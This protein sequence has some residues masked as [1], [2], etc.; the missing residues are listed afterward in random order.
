MCRA[1][2]PPWAI[3]A[4]WTGAIH[5]FF[6]RAYKA[7]ALLRVIC[8]LNRGA[9][10]KLAIKTVGESAAAGRFVFTSYGSL[11][12]E[13]RDAAASQGLKPEELNAVHWS[14]K[15]YWLCAPV[16]A[17]QKYWLAKRTAERL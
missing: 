15:S 11:P 9:V 7:V 17:K 5:G 14:G 2:L 4:L 10:N 3:G 13:V 12:I 1:W 8:F 16:S 6:V